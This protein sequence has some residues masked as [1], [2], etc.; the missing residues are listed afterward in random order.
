MKLT[1]FEN[2]SPVSFGWRAFQTSICLSVSK[3]LGDKSGK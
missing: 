3:T 2:V 1:I